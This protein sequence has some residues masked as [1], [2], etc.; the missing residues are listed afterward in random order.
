MLLELIIVIPAL[1]IIA[2]CVE[3]DTGFGATMVLFAAAALLEFFTSFQPYTLIYHNP[4]SA[5]GLFGLYLVGG[6]A[7]SGVKWLSFV[8]K[9]RDRYNAKIAYYQ[10]L[11]FTDP[12]HHA[13]GATSFRFKVPLDVS[14]HKARIIRWMSYWPASMAWTILD[15]PLRRAFNWLNDRFGKFFQRVSDKAFGVE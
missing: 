9:I 3:N 12:E 6:V 7:W 11:G 4:I 14:E 15:D 2:A 10:D 13:K 1:I 8:Y 5:V